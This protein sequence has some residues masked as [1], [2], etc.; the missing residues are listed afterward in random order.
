MWLDIPMSHCVGA[1]DQNRAR[2][3]IRI[4]LSDIKGLIQLQD[5]HDRKRQD[6][7]DNSSVQSISFLFIQRNYPAYLAACD[8]AYPV[9]G[10]KLRCRLA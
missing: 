5:M 3:R 8:H 7:Q 2:V 6:M 9:I 4:R 1:E 10:L